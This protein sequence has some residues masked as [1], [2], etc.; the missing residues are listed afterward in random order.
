M[1][2]R[3]LYSKSKTDKTLQWSVEVVE[4]DNGSATIIR[5]SMQ[6]GGKKSI[7]RKDVNK[8]TNIGK[9]NENTPYQTACVKA[10]RLWLDKFEDNWVENIEDAGTITFIKPM[11][12]SKLKEVVVNYDDGVYVQPKMNGVRGTIYTHLGDP[13]MWSRERT[14]YTAVGHIKKYVDEYFGEFSPDGEIFLPGESLQVIASLVKKYQEGKSEKLQYWIYDLAIPNKTYEERKAI[15]DAIFSRMPKEVLDIFVKVPTF[16]VRS[17]AEVKVLHTRFVLEGFEGSMIRIGDSEYGFNDRPNGL[18]KNKD[19]ID[20][21]FK[22][23]GFHAEVWHDALNDCHRNLI[24][25]ECETKDG[26]PFDVRPKGSFLQREADYNIGETFIGKPYTVRYQ[27]LS[28]EGIPTILV[29]I[30]IRDYE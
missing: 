16:F 11:L 14:E 2:E 24:M 20:E 9:A 22:I 30:A 15:I 7:N 4:N 29:G 12:A 5:T 10:N 3:I 1:N 8:G 13:T 26:K 25:M 28:D 6:I 27:E 19:F 17:Y 18:L 21:E 23:V